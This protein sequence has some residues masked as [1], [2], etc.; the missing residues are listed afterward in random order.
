MDFKNK[1]YKKNSAFSQGDG[2]ENSGLPSTLVDVD[3]S[4]KC[5]PP[6]DGSGLWQG[7][8]IKPGGIGNAHARYRDVVIAGLSL[9]RTMRMAQARLQVLHVHR[10]GWKIVM[11]FKLYGVGTAG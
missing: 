10:G 4:P 8:G 9:P 2:Y 5:Q 7:V 3:A 1:L 6:F 11:A